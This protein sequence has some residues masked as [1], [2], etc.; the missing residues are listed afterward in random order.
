MSFHR[1]ADFGFGYAN[2]MGIASSGIHPVEH[3]SPMSHRSDIS[4]NQQGKDTDYSNYQNVLSARYNS[5][6]YESMRNT[7]QTINS[8]AINYSGI[9]PTP[10]NSMDIEGILAHEAQVN[11]LGVGAV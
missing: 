8:D 10:A 9:L 11:R 3:Q 5:M 7:G 2:E 4:Y 1:S 6:Y